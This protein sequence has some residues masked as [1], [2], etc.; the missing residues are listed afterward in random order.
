MSLQGQLEPVVLSLDD[1]LIAGH[2]RRAAAVRLKWKTMKARREPISSH[3]P[4][5]P[6]LLVAH[7]SQR[8]K[9]PDVRINEQIVLTD[10]DKAYF[11]LL[12]ERAER[13]R[14]TAETLTLGERKRR[15]NISDAKMPF[16]QAIIDVVNGLK[17]YWPLSDRRIHYSLLNSPP[18]IHSKKP[19][20][21]HDAKGK[22]HHN[23]YAN[24]KECYKATCE[25]LTRARLFGFI[26]FSAIGDET[27]PVVA[28]DV[29]YHV[30][31]F[32][33]RQMDGFCR[34]YARDLLQGQPNHV[35][36]V[37]E[38]L[39]VEGTVRPVAQRFCL[40]Y[41]IGRGYSSLPPRKDIYDRY[42]ESQ[43]SELV[44]LFLSDHDPEG[45]DIAESFAKSMRDDFDVQS[46]SAVKV[47]LK[48]E[49]VE[50]LNLPPNTDAKT[51]SS[52]FK[53]FQERFGTAAYELEAIPPATLQQWLDEAVRT[54]IDV[55]LFNKQVEEEKGDAVQ[56]QAFRESSLEY[57]KSVRFG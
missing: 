28:W 36:I 4:E 46:V 53:R 8:H 26:P 24:V 57:L 9:T 19:E 16:L 23:R 7:N 51:T 14:V 47:A 10:P 31:P 32:V 45:W 13:S 3:D 25:M 30:G 38:K 22:L 27:R 42:R 5:F 37:G 34:G 12:S 49:Q 17:D 21:Y 2:R 29:H 39:T 52:R 44:L 6:K 20:R 48:P 35:E 43:K 33:R 54:V 18:L 41:T 15:C 11:N 1:F 50:I 56:L 55:D 40:P